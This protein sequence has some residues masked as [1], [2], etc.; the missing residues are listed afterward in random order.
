MAGTYV[1]TDTMTRAF[2]QLIET[3]ASSID[4]LV[5]STNAFQ[6][7]TGGGLEER[8][9]MPQSVLTVVQ[10]VPGVAE[11]V[12]DVVGYA[13]VVDPATGEPIGTFGPPT[14]AS[15]WN[16]LNGF[17]IQEGG[18]PPEGPDEVVLDVAM[19]RGHDIQVGDGVEILFEGPPAEFEVVGVARYG[20]SDSLL[21]ATWALFDLR[22]A[23]EVLGRR[24]QLD[25][26]S[27]VAEEGV[28]PLE[29]QRRI[30]EV[31]PEGSEAI[32][33]AALAS[34]QQEQVEEALGFF[35]TALL[36]FALVALF[37][38][39]FII[40]N[41]F[42]I[43][44]AQRTRELG[45]LRALGASRRQ[46][47]SSV[48]LEAVVV[49]MVASTL[50]VLAGIGIALALKA[51]LAAT[52]FDLPT[53]GTVIQMRTF[54]VSIVVGTLVTL[55]AAIVPARRAA[56]VAPVEAL[57]EAQD[58]PGRSLRFRLVSG[59]VVLVAG[60]APLMYGLFGQPDNGLQLVGIGVAVTFI[61]LAMLTP[62]IAGP[63]ARAL[64][65]PVRRTGVLGKL[66]RENAMRNPRRTA[67]TASAL[68]IGL[69]LVVFVAVF[70]ESAKAS[71]D[72]VL[73]RTLRADF[74]LTSPSFTGFSTSAAGELRGVPGVLA[75]SEIRQAALRVEGETAFATSVD[76]AFEATADPW[77]V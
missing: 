73:D 50:G 38:G 24:A 32:T 45:L 47:L 58:S 10:R 27:A 22:T 71:T 12:G 17:T 48:I 23:Q 13:Q 25:S 56:K 29:L 5:R 35:Q 68:M 39:A 63:V 30:A 44:V 18:R 41:T 11:A 7:E 37:V 40:F 43:I 26:V 28:S 46:V 42:A 19:A 65:A 31:V 75:V 4:V 49:G 55:V 76:P 36:V 57:R 20:D 1:L 34:E 77:G 64:G 52:G 51:V 54:V 67:A 70:G 3:G 61:G 74:M 66:G 69:G 60:V 62:L 33:A 8:R 59:S 21:G 14:A 53:S 72:A 15:S 16:D 9:P 2:N 6:A